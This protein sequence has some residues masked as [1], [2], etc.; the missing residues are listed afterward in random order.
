MDRDASTGFTLI[1]LMI[2]I[3]IIA[4]LSAIAF[5]SYTDYVRRGRIAE[6]TAALA[7]QRVS[8]EQYYQDHRSFGAGSACGV[9]APPDA[10]FRYACE[11][12]D[13]GQAFL[14][15]ATGGSAQG[16]TGFIYTIDHGG[17]RRTTGLPATWGTAPLDCWVTAR[18]GA[19]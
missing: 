8:L 9:A 1:E 12:S 13:G 2:S 16:M 3:A 7:A 11:T 10:A 5:P 18:G 19:C 17:L 6:A 4:I 15:T 14:V